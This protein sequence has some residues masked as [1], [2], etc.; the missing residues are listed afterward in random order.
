MIFPLKTE[1]FKEILLGD[2]IPSKESLGANFTYFT[3]NLTRDEAHL[4]TWLG[5]LHK[6]MVASTLSPTTRNWPPNRPAIKPLSPPFKGEEPGIQLSAVGKK[7]EL[8]SRGVPIDKK[9]VAEQE[10]PGSIIMVLATDAPLSQNQL[11]RVAVRAIGQRIDQA[12]R[13]TIDALPV[14]DGRRF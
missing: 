11:R 7:G 14:L 3:V 1:L 5:W 4:P 10:P 8:L 2:F 6:V 12:R 13:V 9:P